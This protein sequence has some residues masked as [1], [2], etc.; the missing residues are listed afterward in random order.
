MQW[1]QDLLEVKG[2]LDALVFELNVH[3]LERKSDKQL[4]PPTQ[5]EINKDRGNFIEPHFE[6]FA[7]QFE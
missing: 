1:S 6:V 4:K 3:E 2:K 5:A 7:G